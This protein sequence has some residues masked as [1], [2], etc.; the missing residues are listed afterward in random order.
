MRN[1]FVTFGALAALSAAICWISAI[2]PAD[3]TDA[4][5]TAP[6]NPTSAAD[7]YRGVN[8][9]FRLDC[10][11]SSNLSYPEY[12]PYG[13]AWDQMAKAAWVADQ[14][15]L[16][17]LREARSIQQPNWPDFKLDHN[18][19]P[20]GGSYLNQ[21]RN[22]ANHAGDAAL[23]QHLQGDD[24]GAIDTTEDLLVMSD[25]LDHEPWESQVRLLVGAGIRALTAYKLMVI[26]SDIKLTSDPADHQSV[27]LDSAR[28]IIQHLLIQNDPVAQWTATA[29]SGKPDEEGMTISGGGDLKA[30]AIETLNRVNAEQSFAA[31]SMACHLFFLDH[32]R[33][34][35]SIE[36]L[37]PAYLPH[38]SIDPWGDGRQTLGYAL[39][40]GGL[41]DGSDRPL[42]YSRCGS[43]GELF[44]R[45][46]EPEYGFIYSDPS[47][48][49][50]SRRL[51]G[52]QFRDVASWVPPSAPG[53]AGPTTRSL[54]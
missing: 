44:Y 32:R 3:R 16:K 13:P 34:P 35:K 46:D 28:H 20:G 29:D 40:K 8:Q 25:L 5:T 38:T 4:Q 27:Q 18:A 42:V 15:A 17:R 36:E 33:W 7:F 41:P 10:P 12:P 21:M 49:S 26:T 11:A 52:G 43:T 53:V 14:A 24:A 39:V 54:K 22:V 47:N 48:P 37:V 30:L 50:L 9:M 45:L 51:R 19:H 23:Y 2:I 6:A 1:S 31:M